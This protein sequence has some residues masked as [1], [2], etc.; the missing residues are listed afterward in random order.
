M[1]YE[2]KFEW[3]FAVLLLVSINIMFYVTTDP[4]IKTAIA[5][6]IVSGFSACIGFIFGKS[7]PDK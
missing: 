6:A 7:I 3:I 4:D 2:I 1:K 5:M